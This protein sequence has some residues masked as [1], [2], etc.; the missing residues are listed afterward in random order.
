MTQIAVYGS[1][2]FTAGQR[3]GWPR[4]RPM[5]GVW[6]ARTAGAMLLVGAAMTCG[7]AMASEW[8]GAADGATPCLWQTS[9][10]QRAGH[11]ES[12]VGGDARASGATVAKRSALLAMPEVTRITLLVARGGVA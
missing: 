3:A 4:E 10:G 11:G 12:V 8:P 9:A 5:A 1:L 6:L 2:A 7:A